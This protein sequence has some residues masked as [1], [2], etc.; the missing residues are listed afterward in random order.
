[1]TASCLVETVA[2]SFCRATIWAYAFRPFFLLSCGYALALTVAWALILALGLDLPAPMPAWQWHA[3][4]MLAGFFGAALAGFILTAVPSWTNSA[5]VIGG[6]LVL[7]V[8][9][10][11]VGRLAMWSADLLPAWAV[12]AANLAFLPLIVLWVTP[13]IL[14]D[15]GRRHRAFPPV[16]TALFAAHAA[17]HW[18]WLAAD[19]PLAERGLEAMLAIFVL[20]IVLTVTRITMVV[21]NAALDELGES[22]RFRPNP[23]RNGLA[24]A[25]VALY[26]AAEFVAPETAVTGWIALAAAAAQLDR[27]TDWHVGRAVLKPYVL[28]LYAAYWWIAIGLALIGLHH[29][30]GLVPESAGRHALGLGAAGAAILAVFVIAGMRHTGHELVVPPLGAAAFALIN[31][32]AAARVATPILAPEWY[33]PVGLGLSSALFVAAL[34]AYLVAF[35]PKLLRPRVDG[36]P[37]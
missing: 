23:A 7:L 20:L 6:R 8:G 3:H 13:Q 2:P 12:A 4:E 9:V 31:A 1:M 11:L 35:T 28:I 36:R 19:A 5:P 24:W 25:T 22:R 17:V 34:L 33:L 32:A 37:G 18:G 16:L 14:R 30:F 26:A 29:V 27:L 15:A 21:I 10:W